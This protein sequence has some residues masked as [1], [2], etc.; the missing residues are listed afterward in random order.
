VEELDKAI[1]KLKSN[2]SPGP[3][4]FCSEWY[5]TFRTELKPSLLHV[6]NKALKKAFSLLC[7]ERLLYQ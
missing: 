5:K 1:S 7:G 6:F 4:G 2:K 3:D